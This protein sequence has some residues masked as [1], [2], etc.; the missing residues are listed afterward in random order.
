MRSISHRLGM[1]QTSEHETDNW[2][3]AR[4]TGFS[5][6]LR[7]CLSVIFIAATIVLFFFIDPSLRSSVYVMA[8]ILGLI[9]VGIYDIFSVQRTHLRWNENGIQKIGLLRKGKLHLWKDLSYVE[10]SM[11]SRATVLTFKSIWKI[12][13]YWAYR[14]HRELAALAKQNLKDNKASRKWRKSS[15]SADKAVAETAVEEM[16]E[17]VAQDQVLPEAEI[18]SD[19]PL[20]LQ[21]PVVQQ[22]D[23]EQP[24][25]TGSTERIEP[26]LTS[27]P[28]RDA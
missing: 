19:E 16:A 23:K 3:E 8:L 17:S 28:N 5:K 26:P 11:N 6:I 9:A 7:L 22:Q 18:A 12:R 10:K 27:A 21:E 13:V 14:A 24:A 15:K 20:V 2:K 1:T 4:Y 25:K